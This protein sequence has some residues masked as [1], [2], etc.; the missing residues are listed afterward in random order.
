[1]SPSDRTQQKTST[2][3]PCYSWADAANMTR[4]LMQADPDLPANADE[5]MRGLAMAFAFADALVEISPDL[6]LHLLQRVDRIFIQQMQR[7][8][9]SAPETSP[10]G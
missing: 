4:T 1:M 10:E 7:Q 2:V 5:Y 8:G 6:P 9:I 3:S